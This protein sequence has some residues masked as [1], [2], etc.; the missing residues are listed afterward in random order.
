MKS[1]TRAFIAVEISSA[2]RM[3]AQQAL[4]P[5]KRDFPDIKWTDDDN[6]HVT[7]KFLG[8]NVPTTELHRLIR[9]VEKACAKSEQ[10]DLVFEGLG[11]FPDLSNPRTIWLG[12][13]DG[14]NELKALAERIE[15]EL[16][17]LGFPREGREF[18]PHM[19]VGRTR[20]RDRI[21]DGSF[22]G[23]SKMI[24][25]RSDMFFGCSSV[26]SVVL[27]SSELE[28]RG[29]RYSP[30][31]TIEL[32]PLGSELEKKFA[33]FNATDYDDPNFQIED[34]AMEERLPETIDSKIDVDALDAEVEEELRTICGSAFAKRPKKFSAA[35]TGGK[36]DVKKQKKRLD[37]VKKEDVNLDDF[38]LSEFKDFRDV[39]RNDA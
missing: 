2:V 8:S 35:P 14:V 3:S 13:S 5:L 17:P 7:L 36:P 16:E 15:E 9:A 29:P 28:R 30:L 19:T 4:R 18:S 37:S 1:T 34:G 21:D 26:D 31:A 27:Y 22:A 12:V 39:K 6:F 11:V 38:D 25:E 20:R 23:L 10:F 32:S 24:E 33:A